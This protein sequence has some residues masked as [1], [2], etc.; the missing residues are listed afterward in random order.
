MA[1]KEGRSM[2]TELFKM[3]NAYEEA[4]DALETI[5]REN[6]NIQEEVADLVDQLAESTK[7]THDLEK[8]KRS[9]EVERYLGSKSKFSINDFLRN[10]VQAALEEAESA[11]ENE[12]SKVLRLQV[13]LVQI[14]QDIDRQI[15]EK[16]E[17]FDNARRNAQRA[18]E[19]MQV[20]LDN[21]IRTR[22]EL[23][24]TKKKMEGIRDCHWEK[25]VKM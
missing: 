19:S 2:S 14:K 23:V 5:K 22:S 3:K 17:E 11:V 6:K 15:R 9:M 10:D 4:L 13:E 21:E 18:I 12:E 8:A 1:Q 16:E 25:V 7:A 20:T 24:R